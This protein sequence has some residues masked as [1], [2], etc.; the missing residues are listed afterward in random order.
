MDCE[1]CY[2]VLL[3]KKWCA[4]LNLDNYISTILFISAM[5]SRTIVVIKAQKVGAVSLMVGCTFYR[6]YPSLL[7]CSIIYQTS[8]RGAQPCPRG[9]KGLL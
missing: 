4:M 9:T 2:S 6:E 8:V 3:S 7:Q 5:D 1:I